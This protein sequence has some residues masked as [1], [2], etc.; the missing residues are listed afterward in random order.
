[1]KLDEPTIVQQLHISPKQVQGAN[2]CQKEQKTADLIVLIP[3]L[4]TILCFYSV[5]VLL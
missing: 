3:L 2:N 1:M 4:D 5:F